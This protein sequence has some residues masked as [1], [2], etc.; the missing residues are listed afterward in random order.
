MRKEKEQEKNITHSTFS[1]IRGITYINPNISKAQG[2]SKTP[3]ANFKIS[4]I[5]GVFILRLVTL[6]N[7]ITKVIIVSEI[8]SPPPLAREKGGDKLKKK[9]FDL[10]FVFLERTWPKFHFQS[11]LFSAI[12]FFIRP[13]NY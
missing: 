5:S 3:R 6:Q 1:G 13:S 7:Y 9:K 8:S 10:M 4:S 2:I 12:R 11:H